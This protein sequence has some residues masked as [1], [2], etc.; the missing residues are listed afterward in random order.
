MRSRKRYTHLDNLFPSLAKD[1]PIAAILIAACVAL[2]QNTQK[3]NAFLAQL[4]ATQ[5]ERN[6]ELAN[7]IQEIAKG[8]A[9]SNMRVAGAIETLADGISDLRTLL[10][11][12]PC[13][14]QDI[15]DEHHAPRR[16]KHGD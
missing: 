16:S 7:S 3:S 13:I 15:I 12:R 9:E 10:G 5:T 4:L 2:W 6:R 1:L 14:A 11:Q 8:V